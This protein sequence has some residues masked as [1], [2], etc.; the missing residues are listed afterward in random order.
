MRAVAAMVVI[1]LSSSCTVVDHQDHPNPVLP[2]TS[3]ALPQVE[4]WNGIEAGMLPDALQQLTFKDSRNT[5]HRLSRHS[6]IASYYLFKNDPAQVQIV[7][8]GRPGR[9]FGVYIQGTMA[10]KEKVAL[11]AELGPPDSKKSSDLLV[12]PGGSSSLNDGGKLFNIWEWQR[13]SI[14]IT[15]ASNVLGGYFYTY[16]QVNNHNSCH[17]A[18]HIQR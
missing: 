4:L 13:G 3:A 15:F 5:I 10:G 8:S 9:A 11:L 17:R 2:A 7:F 18:A 16:Y 12:G 1:V 14:C 6:R